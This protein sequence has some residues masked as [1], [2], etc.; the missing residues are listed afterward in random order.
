MWGNTKF[1]FYTNMAKT[2][3]FEFRGEVFEK[4][5]WAFVKCTYDGAF[6]A[7]PYL[8][9]CFEIETTASVIG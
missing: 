3:R 8:I 7:S 9:R 2:R 5:K 4:A 6:S 1:P